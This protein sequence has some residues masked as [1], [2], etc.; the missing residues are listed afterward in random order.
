LNQRATT[1]GIVFSGFG[2]SA[3][4]F[5]EIAHL[6]FGGD[7]SAYLNLLAWGTAACMLVGLLVV[8]PIPLPG[9]EIH[10]VSGEP[11]S[12]ALLPAEDI[13]GESRPSMAHTKAKKVDIF[14]KALWVNKDFWTLFI[15][16]TICEPSSFLPVHI[17]D[18]PSLVCG[19][20][21][22]CELSQPSEPEQR[23]ANAA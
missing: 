5:S 10:H 17:V 1:A 20:G 13:L 3:F 4:F 15:T 11:G 8:R 14:G 23:W 19:I 9:N 6:A 2:L 12:Y 21:I 18:H 7:T 22:M 16:M